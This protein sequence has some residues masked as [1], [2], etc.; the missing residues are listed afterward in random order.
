MKN[1]APALRIYSLTLQNVFFICRLDVWTVKADDTQEFR[2]SQC[3]SMSMSKRSQSVFEKR[4][5]MSN[6]ENI[7]SVIKLEDGLQVRI[8]IEFAFVLKS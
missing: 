7:M 5:Q 6:L 3:L 2:L 1:F 8:A 4:V